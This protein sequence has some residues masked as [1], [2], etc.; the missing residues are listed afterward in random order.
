MANRPFGHDTD[1][2]LWVAAGAA[3]VSEVLADPACRVRPRSEPVPSGILGTP[4]GDVFGEL[5]R[6]TDGAPQV[7]LKQVLLAALN[8]ISEKQVVALAAEQAR[9]AADWTDLQFGVPARVVATVL[10]LGGDIPAEAA[11]LIGEFVRCVPASAT[12]EDQ[13]AAATAAARLLDLL[14]PCL[15]AGSS[16]LIGELVR[17]A[18]R[19]GLPTTAPLPANVIGLLSQTYDATAG[20]V[21]NTLLALAR[22][23][24]PDDLAG[25]VDEVVRH[26]APIQNT[27]RYVVTATTVAGHEVPAGSTILLLLAAANRD[28]MA[29]PDPHAFLPGR[30]DP[31]VFT[32]GRGT[33]R[34]PGHVLAAAI[35]IGVAA[36]VTGAPSHEGYRPSPN[37]RI[38]VLKGQFG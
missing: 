30:A 28:P 33:H 13:A 32:F 14:G 1:S 29:N 4:A 15:R 19:N 17:L 18:A 2:G 34:C 12:A 5:V 26:D 35:T 27:R 9:K 11:R 31:Q 23:G 36:A 8:T 37:A 7:R 6:M 10:G 21:G 38:P 25:F 16:G 22:H 3:A 20:L 24:K